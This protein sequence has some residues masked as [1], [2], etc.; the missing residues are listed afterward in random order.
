MIEDS[1]GGMSSSM[2][3]EMPNRVDLKSQSTKGLVRGGALQSD[4]CVKYSQNSNSQDI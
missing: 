2:N 3:K 1:T 4:S